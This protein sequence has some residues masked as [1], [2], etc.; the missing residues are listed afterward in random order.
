MRQ[1]TAL[2]KPH[3]GFAT[4]VVP[5][6]ENIQLNRA[7]KSDPGYQPLPYMYMQQVILDSSFRI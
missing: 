6:G 1:V 3:A 2:T 7:A 4:S 5:V